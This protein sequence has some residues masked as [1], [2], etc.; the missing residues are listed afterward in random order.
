MDHLQRS[1]LNLFSSRTLDRAI[2][3]RPAE[4]Q[5]A[6]IIN[7]PSCRFVPVLGTNVLVNQ[8]EPVAGR[9]CSHRRNYTNALVTATNTSILGRVAAPTTSL[10]S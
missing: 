1:R 4:A 7:S 10:R 6:D 3:L 9:D 8:E 5:L 2:F